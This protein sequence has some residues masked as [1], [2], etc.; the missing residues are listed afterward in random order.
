MT[1]TDTPDT[2]LRAGSARDARQLAK[3]LHKV[4][5][6]WD[7]M[8]QDTRRAHYIGAHIAGAVGTPLATLSPALAALGWRSQQMRLAGRRVNV[9]VAPG[10]PI[11]RRPLG[12]PL[13]IKLALE[14]FYD[15]K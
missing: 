9:W 13:V 2:G 14:G 15:H 5:V 11:I 8:P 10:T 7:S 12:R 3:L 1:P 4:S 6:W